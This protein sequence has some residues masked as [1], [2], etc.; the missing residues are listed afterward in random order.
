[1]PPRSFVSQFETRRCPLSDPGGVL[2]APGASELVL[3]TL[4]PVLRL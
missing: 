2:G 1:M 4:A 3:E